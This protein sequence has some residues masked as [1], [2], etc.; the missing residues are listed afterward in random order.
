MVGKPN[1]D[2]EPRVQRLFV[3]SYRETGMGPQGLAGA[4]FCVSTYLYRQLQTAGF[5]NF[6]HMPNLF[7]FTLLLS[8]VA[9][10]SGLIKPSLFQRVIKII[11]KRKTIALVCSG[12]IV[13]SF[14]GIGLTAPQVEKKNIEALTN[15]SEQPIIPQ[16]TTSSDIELSSTD[17][18]I[19]EPENNKV[20][21]TA[22]VKPVPPEKTV[23]VPVTQA[24]PQYEYYPVSSV[25]DGDTVKVNINGTVE[26]LRLIGMDT[27]ETVDPRKPVQ[28]FGKEA[29]NKAKELLSGKK[30]RLEADPTQGE[31][32]KYGRRLAY[33][34]REDGLFFN[35]Y[36]IEQ[37]YAHEY[38]YNTPYKYQTEFKVAQKSAQE[39]LRG[40]W[41]PDTCNGDTTSSTTNTAPT[42]TESANGKY[43]TS[44]Y[45]TSKYYYPVACPEWQNLSSSYLKSFDSLEALLATYPSRVL[46]PQCQ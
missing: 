42:T 15:I 41:S 5:F 10:I 18:N 6:N 13:F 3:G 37:G 39:N 2:T 14:I 1:E 23:S 32:D 34:Y 44:S 27:P 30:V 20:E 26:T 12:V 9:L 36:M 7:L 28:C 8:I 38:T 19:V 11:P 22:E 17:S 35:K 45:H 43:Y 4:G 24:N 33:I 21:P 46:S 31:L 29:S 25:V 40:L 16:P